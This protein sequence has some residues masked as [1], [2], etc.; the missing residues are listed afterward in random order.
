MATPSASTSAQPA[1]GAVTPR[2]WTRAH[3]AGLLTIVVALV[4]LGL[5][6]PGWGWSTLLV[7]LISLGLLLMLLVIAGDGAVDRWTGALIDDRNKFSLSRLQMVVW[8]VVMLSGFLT[9]A[10]HNIVALV[11]SGQPFQPLA[12][13]IPNQLWLMMGISTTAMIGSP[14]IKGIKKD[15]EPDLAQM[16][17]TMQALAAQRGWPTAAVTDRVVNQ[18]QIVCNLST[19]DAQFSDLFK[20][21]E[22]GNAAHL[23]LS[24][25]QMFLFTVVLV[26]AYAVALGNL[27]AS[28]SNRTPITG[29]PNIDPSLVALLGISNAGYLGTKAAPNSQSDPN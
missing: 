8:S 27:F 21:E 20:G 5:L 3:T 6:G 18:G 26:V 28:V 23:D 14:L 2:Q 9:A 7:W 13:T 29:F 22:T 12:I 10:F 15:R 16:Q 17:R 24:R 4:L 25:L 19:R 1:S 11:G